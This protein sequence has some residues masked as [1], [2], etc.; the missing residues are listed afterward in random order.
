MKNNKNILLVLDKSGSMEKRRDST[1]SDYNEYLSGLTETEVNISLFMFSSKVE[2]MEDARQPLSRETYV[3]GGNT[4]LFDAVARAIYSV[5]E[6]ET[7]LVVI[8]SDGEE[9]MSRYQKGT[10]LAALIADKKLVGWQFI[11]MGCEEVCIK[12]ATALALP[13]YANL[14]SS[15][16][17]APDWV[18]GK[19]I[20]GHEVYCATMNYVA[21]PAKQ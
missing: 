7:A 11:F 17:P 12:D 2:K 21:T 18:P 13:F 14:T 19:F 20:K 6:D 5:P 3:P 15:W 1:I 8:L 16:Q 4:A 9:N 10:G